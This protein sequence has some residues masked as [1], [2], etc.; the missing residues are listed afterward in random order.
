MQDP[1]KELIANTVK[2]IERRAHYQLVILFYLQL[3]AAIAIVL[4]PLVWIWD[5]AI[6]GFKIGLT[7]MLLL[8]FFNWVRNAFKDATKEI[9]EDYINEHEL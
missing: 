2:D 6:T 4:S 3:A 1:K 9:I 7:G 5:K 8:F